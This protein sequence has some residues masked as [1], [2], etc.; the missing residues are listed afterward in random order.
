MKLTGTRIGKARLQPKG[1]RTTVEPVTWGGPMAGAK[2]KKT[3][4]KR[5][6]W[7]EHAQSKGRNAR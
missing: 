7:I 3:A 4:R 2:A 5:K 1:K 6:N